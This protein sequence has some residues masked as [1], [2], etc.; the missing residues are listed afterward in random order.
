MMGLLQDVSGIGEVGS[1]IEGIVN[2]FFP[3]KTQQEKDQAAK[4]LQ[5]LMNQYN[6]Q[7]GQL[8]IDEAEANSS[9]PLQHWRGALGW[10]CVYGLAWHFI[11]LP[12][13]EYLMSVL[14][15]LHAI[16]ALPKPPDLNT[17]ELMSLVMTLLGVGTMHVVERV[18]GAA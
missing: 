2:H 9:D 3:D 17:A 15:V 12:I 1:A 16:P 6:L 14:V 18:K 7:A 5:G 11:V 4:D 10:V 13:S 8:K